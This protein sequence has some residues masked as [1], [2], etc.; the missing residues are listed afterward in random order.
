MRD[1]YQDVPKNDPKM[2]QGHGSISDATDPSTLYHW[3]TKAQAGS[4]LLITGASHAEIKGAEQMVRALAKK[5]GCHLIWRF[6]R[7][8]K[9]VEVY[10]HPENIMS[11]TTEYQAWVLLKARATVLSEEAKRG[12]VLQYAIRSMMK[13]ERENPPLDELPSWVG[14]PFEYEDS[15]TPAR[16][17]ERQQWDRDKRLASESEQGWVLPTDMFDDPTKLTQ[18]LD[19]P[20]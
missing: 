14:E 7:E 16:V 5:E 15:R 12:A 1:R 17:L 6:A 19:L 10:V 11:T 8:V 18:S 3:V 9:Q 2:G 20:L 4:R 13:D